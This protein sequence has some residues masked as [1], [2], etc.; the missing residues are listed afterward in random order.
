M[1]TESFLHIVQSITKTNASIMPK[2]TPQNQLS[3]YVVRIV[4][5]L[6]NKMG[7]LGSCRLRLPLR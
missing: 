1:S 3:L 5:M 6:F 4:K 7:A 2:Q